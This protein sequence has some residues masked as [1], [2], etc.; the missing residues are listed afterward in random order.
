MMTRDQRVEAHFKN[1]VR[2]ES[3]RLLRLLAPDDL[4]IWGALNHIEL[5]YYLLD[6]ISAEVAEIQSMK[7][8]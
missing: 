5:L 7:E 2:E 1:S 6:K 3:E 4:I 8:P